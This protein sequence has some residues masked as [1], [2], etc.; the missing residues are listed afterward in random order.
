MDFV[1]LLLFILMGWV[2]EKANI[3]IFHGMVA[4]ELAEFGA[5]MMMYQIVKRVGDELKSRK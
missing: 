4:E 1:L 5:Y 3:H 2:G